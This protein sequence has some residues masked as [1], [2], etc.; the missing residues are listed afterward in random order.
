LAEQI[1]RH[2]VTLCESSHAP[3][4]VRPFGEVVVQ[5]PWYPAASGV[6]APADDLYKLDWFGQ[7]PHWVVLSPP[8]VEPQLSDE[9]CGPPVQVEPHVHCHVSFGRMEPWAGG[10][11]IIAIERR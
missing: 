8:H 5:Q 10:T 11:H 6:S 4:P 1:A 7:P 9:S 3:Y 2:P